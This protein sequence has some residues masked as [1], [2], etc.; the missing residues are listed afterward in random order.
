MM[1]RQRLPLEGSGTPPP[2][3]AEMGGVEEAGET[4][5]ANDSEQCA[6]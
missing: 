5:S 4:S 1:H 3:E 2:P 6:D